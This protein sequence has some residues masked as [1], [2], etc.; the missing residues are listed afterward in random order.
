MIML[1][2]PISE[3]DINRLKVRDQIEIKG[4]IYAGRDAVLPRLVKLLQECPDKVKINLQGGVIFHTAVSLAGIGPTSSNKLEIES[5]I[6]PLSEKGIKIH[7]GK[8]AI[9]KKT[10]QDLQKYNSIFVITPPVT[11]LLTAKMLSKEVVMFPEEGIEALYRLEVSGI[12]GI[13]AIA[14]GESIFIPERE[15]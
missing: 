5:S 15:I 4:T 9:K 8:G 3:A 12:P 13:V 6:G 7:L 10:I 11:A 1:Q 14:H 2:T